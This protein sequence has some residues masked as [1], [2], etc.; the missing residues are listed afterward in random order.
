MLALAA[1]IVFALAL[2]FNLG[3]VADKFF[4]PTDFTIIGLLLLALHLA[5]F[6]AGYDWRGAYRNRR[7]YYSRSRR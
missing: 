3:D 2:L 5:G 1:A 6:G 7:R 4:N